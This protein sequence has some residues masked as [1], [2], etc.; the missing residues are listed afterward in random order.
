MTTEPLSLEAFQHLLDRH[1]G[2]LGRWPDSAAQAA[3][4][5]LAK[6]PEARRLLADS[7]LLDTTL[8]DLPK[9]PPGLVDRIMAASG[10]K[11]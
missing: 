2:A 5:L 6:S 7:L 4:A 3:H 10:A 11:K 9:A 8:A 1:G